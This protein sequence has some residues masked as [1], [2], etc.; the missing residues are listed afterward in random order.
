MLHIHNG[1]STANTMREAGFPGEHFA[2]REALATGPTP[3]G[4]STDDW[5]AVRAAYLAEQVELDA[6]KVKQELG[7]I[8]AKLANI[9]ARE[10]TILW[11]E[12]DLF[13]QINLVYLLDRFA[14]QTAHPSGLSLICIGEFPGIANFSGLGQ[15]TADQMASLFNTRHTV[16]EAELSLGQR[17]WAAYCSPDPHNIEELLATDTSALPFLAGALRQH[18]ARFP[19]IRNGLGDA[20]NKLLAFIAEGIPDFSSLCKAFFDAEPDY[21]LGDLQ[22]RRDLMRMAE[23]AQPLIQLDGFDDSARTNAWLK[24]RCSITETGQRVLAGQADFVHLNSIDLWLGGVHLTKDT[25]WRW[26]EQKHALS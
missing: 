17:A 5:I 1:D 22:I 7:A 11:F 9:A 26:D 10:E 20:E 14:Q 8:D 6:T 2:F 15:L 23:A 24:A 21:G 19:S 18:L 4:L 16:T 13:C 12:H 3:Q 25:L